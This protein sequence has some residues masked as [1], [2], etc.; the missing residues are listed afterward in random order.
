MILRNPHHQLQ[1]E[2]EVLPW[3]KVKRSDNKTLRWIEK[4]PE[5][6]LKTDNGIK[7]ERALAVKK[8]VTYDTKENRITKYMLEQTMHRLNRLKQLYLRL[9]RTTDE[10]VI[11]Q[12]DSM[13]NGINRRINTGFMKE[14][15][16]TAAKFGMSLVFGMAPGYRELYRC[17]LLLQHGLSVTGSIFNISLKDLAVLYEYWCFIKLNSLMKEKYKLKSQDIIRVSG[18]GLI[19]SL[20]KGQ[21]SRVVYE[22]PKNGELITLSYN[23]KEINVPTVTQRPDN[24]LELKKKG[25]Q[26]EY[27]Y[28]F[29]AKYKI[30]P[31]LP[32]TDYGNI[33]KTPGP[34]VE[35]INTMH[36]YRDAIV[37]Q[38]DTSP[39]ERIMFG[40]YV[41]FP[42][43]NEQEYENHRFYKSIDQ[44]N[45]GGLPFLPSATSLVTKMLDELIS[46]SP[47]SAFERA[48]LPRGIE[49]KLAKVDWSKRDVL[50][51]TLEEKEDLYVCLDK[52]FFYIPASR[53][54]EDDLPVHYVAIYETKKLFGAEAKID[55]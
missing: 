51:G 4:H 55:N 16:S 42:Y 36:R 46:D 6:V 15:D 22:N 13:I 49:S 50:V 14:V 17:Y 45:I 44:V 8:Y 43:Q 34:Q 39:Y 18:S 54:H 20:D 41:L 48:T 11:K 1:T 3:H 7:T 52:H 29:D 32:N 31:A 38:S 24:V 33:Y 21:R 2:H 28:V 10:E 19:V 25:G 47:D 27:E 9:G 53:V 35:D 23:P 5:Y 30:N 37:Y 12:I 26:T 40:A